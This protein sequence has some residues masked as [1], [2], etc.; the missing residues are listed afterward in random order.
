MAFT[1]FFRD[2]D[3]LRL[4][5]EYIIP[6]FTGNKYIRIWDAGCAT[7]QEAYSLAIVIKEKMGNFQFRNVRIDA[8]DI[9]ESNHFINFARNGIFPAEMTR[10]IPADIFN[11]YFEPIDHSKKFKVKADIM[12]VIS[13]HKHDLL[14]LE[15]IRRDYCIIV[16][17]NVLLHL[18]YEDRIDVLK[19]FHESLRDGGF[20]V[21]E[22]TQKLP[23]E[24][25]HLFKKIHP[26]GQVYRKEAH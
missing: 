17:K 20:L 12:R 14:S 25:N 15:P 5:Q 6:R 16:C 11:R 10:R 1:F 3:T 19:M 4:I 13:F 2:M 22:Q 21:T 7:G 18:R 26:Q 24:I 9:D 23:E 8:T